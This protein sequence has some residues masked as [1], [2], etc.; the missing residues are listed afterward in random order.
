MKR[1]RKILIIDDIAFE[2]KFLARQREKAVF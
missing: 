2:I 1:G